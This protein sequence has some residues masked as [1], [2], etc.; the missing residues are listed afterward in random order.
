[1]NSKLAEIIAQGY[2]NKH[3][4]KYIQAKQECLECKW[5]A[6]IEN[7]P[8]CYWGVAWKNLV[9]VEKQRKCEFYNKP[10]PREKIREFKP[11]FILSTGMYDAL[12]LKERK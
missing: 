2:R 1:M 8:R 10:S 6:V 3:D 11:S 4:G 7:Q 5:Y 12:G 9:P